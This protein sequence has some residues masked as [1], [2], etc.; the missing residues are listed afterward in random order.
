VEAFLS[1]QSRPVEMRLFYCKSRT[2]QNAKA[3]FKR[4]LSFWGGSSNL[5]RPLEG[6]ATDLLLLFYRRMRVLASEVNELWIF[7]GHLV[8]TI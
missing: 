1:A 4:G 2:T 7:K 5:R 3:W 8:T 6:L